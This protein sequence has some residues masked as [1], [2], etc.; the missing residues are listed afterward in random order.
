LLFSVRHNVIIANNVIGRTRNVPIFTANGLYTYALCQTN[1]PRALF[2]VGSVNVF[3]YNNLPV[4]NARLAY[5]QT[6]GMPYRTLHFRAADIFY[7]PREY[8]SNAVAFIALTTLTTVS[9]TSTTHR[10]T[11]SAFISGDESGTNL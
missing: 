9:V 10:S 4:L 7:S 5:C 11:V 6:T 8:W 3:L 1:A 2:A